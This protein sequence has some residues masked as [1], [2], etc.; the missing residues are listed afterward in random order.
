[1][2]KC[3]FGANLEFCVT[4]LAKCLKSLRKKFINFIEQAIYEACEP[5]KWRSGPATVKSV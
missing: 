3:N 1:M 2:N 4:L 5:Q